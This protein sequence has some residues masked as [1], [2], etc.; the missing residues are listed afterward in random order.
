M[1][2]PTEPTTHD[3]IHYHTIL[4]E[5]LKSDFKLVIEHSEGTRV[6]LTRMIEGLR[7]EVKTELSDFKLE[8]RLFKQDMTA[9]KQ[10][11]LEWQRQAMH[12][13]LKIEDK[14]DNH[15]ERLVRV[16]N[17]VVTLQSR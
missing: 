6:S 15:E 7:Q 13:L 9:F 2:K 5:S 4:L 16:E 14:I 10:D 8:M 12:V 17:D 11:T 3:L 1:T